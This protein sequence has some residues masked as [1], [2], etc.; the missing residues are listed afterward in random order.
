MSELTTISNT[1]NKIAKFFSIIFCVGV[2]ILIVSLY[3]SYYYRATKEIEF[4]SEFST[5]SVKS[6][7]YRYS[8][9]DFLHFSG[10][11]DTQPLDFY[12]PVDLIQACLNKYKIESKIRANGKETFK[13]F[14]DRLV[15]Y[16][17]TLEGLNGKDCHIIYGRVLRDFNPQ[18]E[19]VKLN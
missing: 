13:V 2:P 14:K 4:N 18:D 3:I 7:H 1:M 17:I 10:I 11:R 5:E 15:P 19:E 9:E 8:K 6:V 16:S 12:I